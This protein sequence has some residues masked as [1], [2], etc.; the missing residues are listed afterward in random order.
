MRARVPA[1]AWLRGYR[2]KYLKGDLIAGVV[3]AIMLIPQAMAYALLAGLPPQMG[4]YAALL[5]IVVYALLGTS[6]TLAVGPL[7]IDSLMVAAALA[8]VAAAGSV[9]Y[10]DAAATLTV[11]VGG[12]LLVLGLVRAGVLV[13]FLSN[14]VINGF[15]SAAA[16]VIAA[17]QVKYLLGIHMPPGLGFVETMRHILDHAGEYNRATATLGIS[18]VVLLLL[19]R[20]PLAALLRRMRIPGRL[21][22]VIT[23][24]EAL[25]VILLAAFATWRLD[26]QQRYGVSVVG[27][28]PPGLPALALPRFDPGLAAALL[29]SAAL[30]ALVGFMESISVGRAFAGKRRQRV[31]PNRELTALGAANLAAAVSGAYV[32][33]GGVSRT[34]VNFTA[35]ANTPLASLITAS[36]IAVAVVSLTP[37]FRHI[38]QAALGA[39]VVL[40]VLRLFDL[41]GLRFAWR[42]NKADAVSLLVTFVAVLVEG[43]AAGILAGIGVSLALY[44]WRTSRPHVAIVGRMGESEHFRSVDR[45][46]VRT[47]PHVVAVRVDESLYFANAD[48]LQDRLL[49]VAAERQSVTHVVLVCSAINFIDAS[50]L[51]TLSDVRVRLCDAGVT[52]HLAEVKEPVMDALKRSD[53]L[54]QLAPGAVF[55]SAHEAMRALDCV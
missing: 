42:Y 7:A 16:V 6:M 5:P 23:R 25:L 50:A 52:L 27:D 38:P 26:L 13:S 29:P 10:L 9:A 35:G 32:V 37:W 19:A 30:I 49:A 22:R 36:L 17:S 39:V 54:Q 4:L 1:P 18:C 34:S 11:L 41:K 31:E 53:F 43:L 28:L 2:R 51:E 20:K 15:T 8:P 33:A 48:L 47:C 12:I 21:V 14:P 24:T 45:H 44:L 3:V 46:T 55:L 40:A